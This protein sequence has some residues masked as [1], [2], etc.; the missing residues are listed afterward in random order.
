MKRLALLAWTSLLIPSVSCSLR[1]RQHFTVA[2]PAPEPLLIAE[3]LRVLELAQ[4]GSLMAAASRTRELQYRFGEDERLRTVE[5]ILSAWVE[6]LRRDAAARAAAS[7]PMV[8]APPPSGPEEAPPA[9]GAQDQPSQVPS[10][11]DAP[12]PDRRPGLRSSSE[13]ASLKQRG[14]VLYTNGALE[15]ALICWRQAQ[16]LDPDDAET[17]QLILRAESIRAR[18]ESQA[19]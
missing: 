19:H 1:E 11:P 3:A 10:S 13:A 12:P 8:I 17:R 9:P 4:E 7:G 18:K 2:P 14:I 5:R 6:T 16:D 15:D